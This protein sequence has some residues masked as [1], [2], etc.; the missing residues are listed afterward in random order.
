M[1]VTL[2][3]P[4]TD[5]ARRAGNRPKGTPYFHYYKLG[6]ATLAG[7]TPPEIDIEDQTIIADLPRA[8]LIDVKNVT[9][10]KTFQL[11]KSLVN[12][13]RGATNDVS[14]P[15]NTVSGFHATIEYRDGTY[16]LEDQRSRNKTLL[17]GREVQP[18]TPTRLKSGDEIIFT[19]N[20]FIFLISHQI[21]S[22]DTT[23][24]REI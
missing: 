5:I 4:A 22:G 19:D 2:V 7:A 17:N 12:I 18:F 11:S 20:K 8:M 13:G 3:A 9:T 24:F 15:R 1:K 10:R 14:I 21:P 16:Y 23:I 6:I